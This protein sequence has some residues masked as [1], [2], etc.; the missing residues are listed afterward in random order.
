MD[1]SKHERQPLPISQGPEW[2][3]VIPVSQNDAPNSV[4]QITYLERFTEILGYFQAI[5]LYAG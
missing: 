2:S 4:V 5:Y 3:D 1:F